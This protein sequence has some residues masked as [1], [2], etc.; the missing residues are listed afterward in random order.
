MFWITISWNWEHLTKLKEKNG[1]FRGTEHNFIEAAMWR[2]HSSLSFEMLENG[3]ERVPPNR[4]RCVHFVLRHKLKWNVFYED[5][6]VSVFFSGHPSKVLQRVWQHKGINGGW[7]WLWRQRNL[8]LPQEGSNLIEQ[9]PFDPG[10]KSSR[11]GSDSFSCSN[12]GQIMLMS[13]FF[14]ICENSIHCQHR[15]VWNTPPSPPLPL[16]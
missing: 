3:E 11:S 1:R 7:R 4:P 10:V 5:V 14:L 6:A 16:L 15:D 13:L 9:E 2:K 12:L 8:V